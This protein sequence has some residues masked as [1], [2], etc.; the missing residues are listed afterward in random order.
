[1]MLEAKLWQATARTDA[2]RLT[3]AE[4]VARAVLLASGQAPRRQAWAHAVLSRVLVWQGRIEEAAAPY[5]SR[6]QA[7]PDEAAVP[8]DSVVATWSEAIAIRALLASGHLFQAGLRARTL[9]AATA[10]I[11]E[12]LPRLIAATAHLRVLAAAGDLELAGQ[13]L[14]DV[15]ALARLARA[16]LRAVWARLIWCD[17][18][19]RAGRGADARRVLSRLSR[20]G[21]VA[22]ALL[23]REIERRTDCSGDA[24]PFTGSQAY[25][26]TGQMPVLA[27]VL[28]RLSHAEENDD[29]ALKQLLERISRELQPVRLDLVSQD[30]GPPSVVITTG[31]GLPTHLGARVLESGVAI[32]ERLDGGREH[33][34]PVRLGTRLLGALVARW[35]IDRR[36]PGGAD[37][38]LD[39]AGAVAAPRLE[40]L[41]ASRRESSRASTAVPELIGVSAEM[42]AVRR[43]I[44]RAARAPFAVMIEGESGVGKELAAR[45]VHQLGPRRERQLCDVNCAALPDELLESELF[46]HARGAFTGAVVEKAGLFEDAHGGTLFLDEVADLTPRGQAKL[47]RVLQQHEVRRVGETFSRKVDVRVVTAANRD[48]RAEVAAGRFRSDLLY[49]LDVIRIRI[50]PLRERPGDIPALA[51][52]FW[53]ASS[54]RVGCTATLTHGVLSALSSYHW[55]GNVR[56]LQNVMAA[57]AVAAPA[58]GSVRASLLPAAITGSARVTSCRLAEARAEFE[59][60]CVE[61]ALARA[62]GSRTRAAAA[63]GL[64]RQGLLKTMARLGLNAGVAERSEL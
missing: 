11:R 55:P 51:N 13:R 54:A 20:L 57:L 7:A 38:I 62:G 5:V 9:V 27:A 44:E 33:G 21:R 14:R 49:R 10:E 41:Q 39:M 12:P 17:A 3:D 15:S 61:V 37:E 23:K 25:Q 19:R 26:G 2:A 4:S 50:P 53:R 1:M 30:A 16:P 24:T 43:A 32:E 42:A 60:R 35:P 59:R 47:L 6:P 36:P 40:A 56:E 52:H 29:A 34:V 48:M 22:P 46:G 18:L 31:A 28:V 64:S 45:A 58:R 63:L 8:R